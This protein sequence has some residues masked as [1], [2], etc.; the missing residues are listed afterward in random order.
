MLA[1]RL[2]YLEARIGLQ[3][4]QK[5]AWDAFATAMKTAAAPMDALC[6]ATDGPPRFEAD[7]LKRIDAA[8]RGADA[9]Q[10][11]L[12]ATRDALQ[13][14]LP[15]LTTAQREVV[16]TAFAPPPP[17]PGGRHGGPGGHGGPGR[18][19]GA[20]PGLPSPPPGLPGLPGP[21]GALFG[22]PQMTPAAL[23]DA[24]EPIAGPGGDLAP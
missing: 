16:A 19:P 12:A 17:P 1:G 13:A 3:A 10:K 21:F 7:P 20:G 15:S 11:T 14:L 22:S 24:D 5:P 9:M 8:Q 4:D 18:G 2:A 23:G 6:A